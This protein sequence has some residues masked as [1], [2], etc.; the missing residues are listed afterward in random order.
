MF[1]AVRGCLAL[2]ALGADAFRLN[3]GAMDGQHTDLESRDITAWSPEVL[4]TALDRM[5]DDVL[6][7]QYV[8]REFNATDLTPHVAGGKKKVALLFMTKD[9]IDQ[10]NLW[11]NWISSAERDEFSV[12]IHQYARSSDAAARQRASWASLGVNFIPLV[13]TGWGQLS[14]VEYALLW[15]ALRDPL[16]SQFVFLSEGH[17]PLKSPGFVYDYLMHDSQSSKI[18]FNEPR[19]RLA[20]QKT[21]LLHRCYYKDHLRY[22]ELPTKVYSD[23]VARVVDVAGRVLKHHQWLVLSRTHAVDVI[24]YAEDGMRQHMRALTRIPYDGGDPA[25]LGASDESFVATTLLLASEKK[26]RAKV[27]FEDEL[28]AERIHSSCTTFVYWRNCWSGTAL[29]AGA[30]WGGNRLK[31]IL[32]LGRAAF[33]TPMGDWLDARKSPA[34]AL[35]DSPRNFGV[36]NAFPDGERAKAY[37]GN[38]VQAGF[39]FARKFGVDESG[40]LTRDLSAVLPQMWQ[41]WEKDFGNRTPQKMEAE[42]SMWPLLDVSSDS[43]RASAEERVP[44]Y[45]RDED[46]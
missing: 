26:G 17:V 40:K 27:S 46:S 23:G 12:Y 38:L 29:G 32:K 25:M 36:S 6:T 11:H 42:N 20:L 7:M 37:V 43:V 2:A 39:L 44:K 10:H 5:F 41:A 31:D 34:K 8:R 13:K 15:E 4:D 1:R 18:C 35:N 16:N 22:A 3:D 21:E 14:G 19:E 24:N 33:N 28:E 45:A 30:G 9:A